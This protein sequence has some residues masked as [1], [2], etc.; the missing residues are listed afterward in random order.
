[1]RGQRLRRLRDRRGLTLETLAPLLDVSITYLGQLERG[2]RVGPIDFWDRAARFF[3][4]PLDH[5]GDT[6]ETGADR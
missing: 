2:D 3:G 5:F 6:S 1:M 4:V